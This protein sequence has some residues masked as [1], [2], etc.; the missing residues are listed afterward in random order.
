MSV[1][2]YNLISRHHSL[3]SRWP[4]HTL[5]VP[6]L[7]GTTWL[8]SSDMQGIAN[9]NIEAH[10]NAVCKAKHEAKRTSSALTDNKR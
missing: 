4:T 10:I 2:H 8:D 9:V 1:H 5:P 6:S 7:D 3:A